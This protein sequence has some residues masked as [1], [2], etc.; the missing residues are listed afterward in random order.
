MSYISNIPKNTPYRAPNPYSLLF[1]QNTA[2]YNTSFYTT[3]PSHP[4]NHTSP[5]HTLIQASMG[6]RLSL[7]G[8]LGRTRT[9][10]TGYPYPGYDDVY[11]SSGSGAGGAGGGV[12][13]NS[14]G[15]GLLGRALQGVQRMFSGGARYTRYQHNTPC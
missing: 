15:D 8:G 3:S 2:F 10:D 4:T 6:S 12:D 11:P 9:A 13:T 1:I 5:S 14:W 7:Q